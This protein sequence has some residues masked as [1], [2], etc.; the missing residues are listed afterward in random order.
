MELDAVQLATFAAVVEEG[1]FDAAAR[2]LH[3]TPS[4]VSQRVKALEQQLG[5]VLVRRSKPV[6]PTEAGQALVRLAGQV[7]LLESEALVAVCGNAG[8]QVTRIPVA[9]NADSLVSWFLPA[10]AGLDAEQL[11]C[12]D[13]HS[14]DQDHS[15]ELLRDGSVMAAVTADP[16][17]V[18]GCRV[19]RLGSMRYLAMAAS[20]YCRR[21]VPDGVTAEALA[22]APMLVF[23]RKDA[24][25]HRFLRTVTRRRLAPPVHYV[26]SPWAFIEAVRLGLGW[27]MVPEEIGRNDRRLVELD[28]GRPV[29]VPLYWQH[30]NLDSPALTALTTSVRAAAA[31]SLR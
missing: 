22:R 30:W 13:L 25:Q 26:P 1:S 27:G 20:A 6:R 15:A 12:F 29:D 5:Q 2:R 10:L 9:V 8:D 4:A 14:E 21:W 3:V 16:N 19:L 31:D 18:Q 23:N 28:G 24:L 11:V 7:A 17:P